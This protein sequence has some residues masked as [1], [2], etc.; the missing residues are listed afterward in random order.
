MALLLAILVWLGL[1]LGVAGTRL[2]STIVART[3]ERG[4]RAGFS[5]ASIAALI[6]L[7]RAYSAARDMQLWTSPA[8]LA[9][10]L[11]LLMLPAFLFFLAGFVPSPT[12]MGPARAP[13][14]LQRVTRHPM[15]WSFVYWAAAHIL[16]RGTVAGMLFFGTFLVTALLG[17]PSIDAK[18]ASRDP[19]GWTRFAAATSILPFAA[20][21]QNRT[22]LSFAEIGW[23]LPLLALLLWA[24]VLL[25][26]PLV[27]GV[28][29][30]PRG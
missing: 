3:G 6:W 26:H 11:V 28:P 4:F 17:M 16:L 9:W 7:I 21:A 29:A 19:R 8:W 5:V 10:V 18:A 30:L 27:I 13:H 20:I 14:G 23:R 12:G 1:H 25:L 22:Q 15:L 24:I 2:R